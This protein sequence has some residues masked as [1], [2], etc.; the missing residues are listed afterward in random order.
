MDVEVLFPFR[1]GLLAPQHPLLPDCGL[2]VRSHTF[3]SPRP[4][5]LGDWQTPRRLQSALPEAWDFVF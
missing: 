3:S 1:E 5:T 4:W 2:E